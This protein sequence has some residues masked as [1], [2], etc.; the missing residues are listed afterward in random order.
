MVLV[1]APGGS[2]GLG[3]LANCATA[4]PSAD[5]G[6]LRALASETR[7]LGSPWRPGVWIATPDFVKQP[8]VFAA[9]PFAPWDL[10]VI[11][12]AHDVAGASDR[13]AAC[14]ALAR[15]ARRLLLLTATPHSGNAAA[16]GRLCS[17]GELDVPAAAGD[18]LAILR[19]TPATLGW[20]T[21]RRT[22]W[23]R[24]ALTAAEA[25]TI[26]VLIDFERHVLLGQRAHRRP[27]GICSCSRSSGNARCRRWPR[28][29][30][31]FVVGPPGSTNAEQAEP[32]DWLQH[33]LPFE[34]GGSD[35][36]QGS[37]DAALSADIGLGHARERA[38]LRR[39]Q[40]LAERAATDDSR[41]RTIVSSILRVRQAGRRSSRSFVARSIAVRGAR[42]RTV[43][44]VA[45]IHGGLSAQE[46][47]AA[48]RRFL[49]GA[50]DV[51]IATDVAG[52]G[53]NLQS[54]ARWVINLEVPWNP[55]RLAQR[56]GRVDRIGQTAARVHDHPSWLRPIRPSPRCSPTSAGARCER[57]RPQV[58]TLA[59]CDGRLTRRSVRRSSAAR[60]SRTRSPGR[61]RSSTRPGVATRDGSRDSS[62]S[63]AT[64]AQH[65]Q[66][67]T[68]PGRALV[69]RRRRG[70]PMTHAAWVVAFS[71]AIMDESGAVVETHLAAYRIATDRPAF[72]SR[73]VIEHARQEVASRLQRRCERVRRALDARAR[74]A[75]PIER[76]IDVELKRAR[77]QTLPQPGLFDRSGAPVE[78]LHRGSTDARV[79]TRVTVGRVV[80]VCAV[81]ESQ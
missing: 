68:Q 31:R 56:A 37:E 79:S 25:K 55:A 45:A 57:T 3:G 38:W 58:W 53:L 50:V 16:F 48:L 6:A 24:I 52:Q 61:P 40:A 12:E 44:S 78:W 14:D 13:H 60:L 51:L 32:A 21:R 69:A 1:L 73:P 19:R 63:G 47:H 36:F 4:S 39:L 18:G 22:R 34:D 66:G 8:H 29:L 65:W 26:D 11:D 33:R 41:I 5:A 74:L 43:A 62:S 23:R 30:N 9:I 7:R 46:R 80:L 2:E 70:R 54:R 75:A 59:A 27:T 20:P 71:A 77:A 10:I 67:G 15:R 42:R 81:S 76:A 17:L 64:W 28:W 49:D 72:P 35:D